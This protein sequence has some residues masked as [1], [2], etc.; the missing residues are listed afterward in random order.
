MNASS[1]EI[2]EHDLYR[3]RIT[4][5]LDDPCHPN[6]NI[7]MEFKFGLCV[8][9]GIYFGEGLFVYITHRQ[10]L[11]FRYVSKKTDSRCVF[12]FLKKNGVDP[13]T[14]HYLYGIMCNDMDY[15]KLLKRTHDPLKF[16][17]ETYKKKKFARCKNCGGHKYSK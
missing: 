2:N 12:H 13:M 7:H 11:K 8:T 10:F 5:G 1:P 14:C 17:L 6:M 3:M 16:K 9:L 4:S 15:Y